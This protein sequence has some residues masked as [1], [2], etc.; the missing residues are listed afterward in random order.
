MKFSK[1]IKSLDRHL[2]SLRKNSSLINR[3]YNHLSHVNVIHSFHSKNNKQKLIAEAK[4]SLS[5]LLEP[6]KIISESHDIPKIIWMF[7]DSGYE[8]APEVIKL[9]VESWKKMNPDYEIKLL[10]NDNLEEYLDFD[11]YAIY[12]L[13]TIRCLPATKADLLRLHLLSK[14]GGVWVDTTTFCLKPLNQWLVP[15]TKHCGLFT[16][17]H[18][19]NATRPI[20]AWFIAAPKGNCIINNVLQRFVDYIFIER[21]TTLFISGKVKLLEKAATT[22]NIPLDYS[23]IERAE[24]L[25]FMPYFSIGYFF[26]EELRKNLSDKQLKIFLR[27]DDD[28]VMINKHALTKDDFDIFSHSLVSKQTYTN[29]YME[30]ALYKKRYQYLCTQFKSQKDNLC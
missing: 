29:S 7:W 28:K 4:I 15:N 30:G 12:Q 24:K 9:S 26:Y 25:G 20:E 3:L 27:E 23:T 19:Y 18:K 16:F 17:K 8:N 5:K 22:T 6:T 1:Q 14:Y 21:K 13:S 11:F 10:C 2:A